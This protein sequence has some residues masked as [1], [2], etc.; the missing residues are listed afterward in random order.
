MEFL[1]GGTGFVGSNILENHRFD[2]VFHSRNIRE[3]YDGN[4]DLLVYAG[5][6]AEMF[7]A[8]SDPE[9]DWKNIENAI[10]NIKR[11]NPKKI[12]LIS[13]I[14]V[15]NN[16]IGV[17][18][19][20]KI[21]E[22]ELSPYG[23]HRYRLE[24]WVEENVTDHLIIR[25]PALYGKNLKKNFI[26]D[27]INIIPR[28][29]K[30]DKFQEL[31][32][33]NSEL[34]NFYSKDSSNFYVCKE[35]KEDDRRYLKN[36]FEGCGFNALDF[37]DSRAVYQFYNLKYL[38]DHIC[39]ALENKIDKLNIA[40]EPVQV[41]ELYTGLNGKIFHNELNRKFFQYDFR[42]KYADLFSGKDGYIFSKEYVIRDIKKYIDH[43]EN[44]L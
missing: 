9:K 25:L 12:V 14:A 28:M 24:K 42:T 6:R 43:M 4:P 37:T 1:V 11:I 34:K 17:D 8:N 35:L 29:L 16:P 3:A 31:S 23:Y 33:R 36:F 27:Y 18:E 21:A 41:S 5:V 38:W 20:S 40:T 32:S 39:I 10:D 19:D 7:L 13:T 30:E 26:Y 15:Y 22:D 2:G 44:Q